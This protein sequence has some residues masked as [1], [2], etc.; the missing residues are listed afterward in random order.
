M[1]TL[2]DPVVNMEDRIKYFTSV[3]ILSIPKLEKYV[4]VQDCPRQMTKTM[5][6]TSLH[7][8]REYS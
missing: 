8:T 1:R 2:S 4:K 5:E 6:V 7:L 3:S